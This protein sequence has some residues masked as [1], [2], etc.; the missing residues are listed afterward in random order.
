MWPKFSDWNHKILYLLELSHC[1]S[2]VK[3]PMRIEIGSQGWKAKSR[4]LYGSGLELSATVMGISPHRAG[5]TDS[6]ANATLAIRACPLELTL[7][8]RQLCPKCSHYALA[9]AGV[10]LAAAARLAF[11]GGLAGSC[12]SEFKHSSMASAM[13]WVSCCLVAIQLLNLAL[14]RATPS[15]FRLMRAE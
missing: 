10:A 7:R 3:E 6:V 4:E 1:Y 9:R 11:R 13:L 15:T 12:T 2:Y 5:L 14:S 8:D